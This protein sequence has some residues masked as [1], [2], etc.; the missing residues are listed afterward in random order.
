MKM[1]TLIYEPINQNDM[2]PEGTQLFFGGDITTLRCEWRWYY[3]D[4]N[5]KV[6]VEMKYVGC[7]TVS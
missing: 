2:P 5:K 3:Y 1:Q 7:K 4:K 6:F